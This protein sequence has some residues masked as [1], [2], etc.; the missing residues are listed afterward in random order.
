[1]AETIS[2]EIEQ[3]HIINTPEQAEQFL[4]WARESLGERVPVS[5]L[6][7]LRESNYK[8]LD[9]LGAQYKERIAG[10]PREGTAIV[11]PARMETEIAASLESIIASIEY[12]NASDTDVKPAKAPATIFVAINGEQEEAVT[13][14][15]VNQFIQTHKET[16]DASGI[17]IVPLQFDVQGKSSAIDA[18]LEHIEGLSTIPETF[19]FI[20]ADVA[21]E[22]ECLADMMKELETG[23]MAV[24]S[25]DFLVENPSLIQLI[26]EMPIL[27][28][29]ER[30][31][32]LLNGKAFAMKSDLMT[33]WHAFVHAFPGSSAEDLHYSVALA[34]RGIPYT[35]TQKSQIRTGLPDTFKNVLKQQAR[36]IGSVRQSLAFTE[37]VNKVTD[38]TL[39][40]TVLNRIREYLPSFPKVTAA[41]A[42]QTMQKIDQAVKEWVT[43]P[44][45]AALFG[46][47][48]LPKPYTWNGIEIGGPPKNP[49]RPRGWSSPR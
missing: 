41:E 44:F 32:P 34:E 27:A 14:D 9:V 25:K 13:V 21:V 8:V 24:A 48:Y 47:N 33:D 45:Y 38:S 18:T 43:V 29:K 4:Q 31:T 3:T 12:T 37:D 20:D 15:L 23:N 49:Y 28:Q 30:Q 40:R 19:F 10:K 46:A 36:W 7:E 5:Q 16:L 2:A 22:K 42:W 1:M 39:P 35:Q 6:A 17:S 11:I 26:A